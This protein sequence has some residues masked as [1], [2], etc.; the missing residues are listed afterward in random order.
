MLCKQ[1]LKMDPFSELLLS[2]DDEEKFRF[3]IYRQTYRTP[4]AP[5]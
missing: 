3:V 1:A 4:S 5:H 2:I